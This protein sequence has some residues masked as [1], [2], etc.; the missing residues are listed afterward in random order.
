MNELIKVT[1][2]Q[3][4]QQVVSA[5]ELYKGLEIKKRFSKWVEQNFG[6]FI[7]GTDFTTVPQ[8]TV[9]ISGNGTER[10]YDDYALTIDMAKQLAMMSHMPKGAEY[11]RYFLEVERKWNDPAEVIKRG[12]AFLQDENYQLH[13]KN[14]KLSLDNQTMAPKAQYFDELVEK[15]TL[16]NFRDTAKMIGRRQTEFIDWLLDKKFVYRDAHK[17]LKPVAAYAGTYFVIKDN[18]KGFP[19]TMITPQGRAAFNRLFGSVK[20]SEEQTA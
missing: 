12:Y 14:T 7:E 11:R 3:Q 16:T 17:K 9:V 15:D 1:Q 10:Q 4:H 6:G 5:R 8:G 20:L 13:V 18:A 2:N 19:Q